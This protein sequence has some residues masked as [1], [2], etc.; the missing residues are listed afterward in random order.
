MEGLTAWDVGHRGECPDLRDYV[1]LEGFAVL[2]LSDNRRSV[3][4]V[5]AVT[6]NDSGGFEAD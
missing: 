2:V 6:L 1:E 4:D 3:P 5:E